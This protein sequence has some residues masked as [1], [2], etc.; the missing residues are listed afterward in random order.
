[1]K[2]KLTTILLALTAVGLNLPANASSPA[3]LPAPLPEF[4]DQAQ[5]AKWNANLATSVA[6]TSANPS[7]TTQF[8]TGKPYV[9]EAGGYVFKYRTYSPEIARWTTSDPSGFPDGVNN[10]IYVEE[11]PIVALD[12]DGLQTVTIE[13]DYSFQITGARASY[14]AAISNAS[15]AAVGTAAVG[16]G[17]GTA[18]PVV[19][20]TLGAALGGIAGFGVGAAGNI[21][22][23]YDSFANGIVTTYPLGS[24]TSANANAT[25]INTV[26]QNYANNVTLQ[27]TTTTISYTEEDYSLGLTKANFTATIDYAVVNTYE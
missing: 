15:L 25:L 27:S 10:H 17:V 9:A 21:A 2:T 6:P 1:M 5:T 18:F 23:Q 4:M 19:G 26:T 12:N 20:T 22:G 8:Y 11:S 3:A 16:A 24:A 7:S 13:Q 14:L